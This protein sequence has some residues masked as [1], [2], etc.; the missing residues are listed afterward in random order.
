[1]GKIEENER[2]DDD[3]VHGL[4]RGQHDAEVVPEVKI[5]I[6]A[7]VQVEVTRTPKWPGGREREDGGGRLPNS[8]VRHDNTQ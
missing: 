1:M 5:Q 3:H 7:K 8:K 4:A 6:E 2:D